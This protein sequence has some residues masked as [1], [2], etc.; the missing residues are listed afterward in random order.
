MTNTNKIEYQTVQIAKE[1]RQL[2]KEYCEERGLKMG[3]FLGDLIATHCKLQPKP[4]KGNVLRVD[5]K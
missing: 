3:H 2:L 1:R 5:D 4:T